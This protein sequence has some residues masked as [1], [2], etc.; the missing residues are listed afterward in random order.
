M[1]TPLRYPILLVDL[2]NLQIFH[3]QSQIEFENKVPY[4]Q[5]YWQKKGQ[6][7]VYGPFDSV[8]DATNHFTRMVINER[9]LNRQTGGDNVIQVDFKNKKRIGAIK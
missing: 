9:N 5:V 8:A 6:P 2:G 7:L 1:T 4:T 3:Y